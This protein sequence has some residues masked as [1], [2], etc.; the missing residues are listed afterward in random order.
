M[1]SDYAIWCDHAEQS[2]SCAE[3]V[4]GERTNNPP[5]HICI[6]A[7]KSSVLRFANWR[8]FLQGQVSDEYSEYLSAWPLPLGDRPLREWFYQ[9]R[10]LLRADWLAD[11]DLN[12]SSWLSRFL[13]PERLQERLPAWLTPLLGNGRDWCALAVERRLDVGRVWLLGLASG[14]WAECSRGAGSQRI[15]SVGVRAYWEVADAE[16]YHYSIPEDIRRIRLERIEHAEIQQGLRHELE[17]VY[18]W[19]WVKPAVLIEAYPTKPGELAAL[20][21]EADKL[22]EWYNATLLGKEL[23][24]RGGA[25]NIHDTPADFIQELVTKLEKLSKGKTR[26]TRNLA[27]QQLNID[28]ETLK[29]K[30][31]R[32]GLKWKDA[33]RL[34][35]LRDYS[36][37]PEWP[38]AW[39]RLR[40]KR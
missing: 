28:E 17:V 11:Q 4:F 5:D 34:D 8:V 3:W 32:L 26:I 27:A 9:R 24:T 7:L 6:W 21:A 39:W 12:D 29:D 31:R 15:E 36:P 2:Q 22:L 37:P 1:T 40:R 33:R 16:A 14:F 10:L 19:E 23:T 38:V 25:A 13:D 18:S 30:L 35:F 20:V